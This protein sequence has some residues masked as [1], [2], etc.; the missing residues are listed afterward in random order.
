MNSVTDQKKRLT[1]LPPRRGKVMINIFRSIFK[2]VKRSRRPAPGSSGY[3]S[4]AH[5]LLSRFRLLRP[6]QPPP[7]AVESAASRCLLT[8]SLCSDRSISISSSD[9]NRNFNELQQR[10][11]KAILRPAAEKRTDQDHDHPKHH[12]NLQIDAGRNRKKRERKGNSNF[13]FDHA[14]A[15][16]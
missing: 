7:A 8:P 10:T 5:Q 14:G 9:S 16:Y 15:R 12:R 3:N 6:P 11:E 4:E 13:G 1:E 2:T